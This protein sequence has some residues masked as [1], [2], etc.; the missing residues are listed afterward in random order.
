[1]AYIIVFLSFYNNVTHRYTE[2]FWT[3][4]EFYVLLAAFLFLPKYGWRGLI[5]ATAVPVTIGAVSCYFILPESPRWL[6]S[7]GRFKEAEKI[8]E[9]CALLSP[10]KP[11]PYTFDDPKAREKARERARAKAKKNKDKDK[12]KDKK[13]I[14]IETTNNINTSN[15]A[16]AIDT[17]DT[18]ASARTTSLSEAFE[19]TYDSLKEIMFSPQMRATTLKIGTVWLCF[20][21]GYY[22]VILL[23]THLYSNQSSDNS[24]NQAECSFEYGDIAVNTS[25]EVAGII[26]SLLTI[27]HF[28]RRETQ[29]WNYGAGA[30][31]L[32]IMGV[33][34]LNRTTIAILGYIMRMCAMAA[35]Q[36]T[37]VMTPELY[38]TR[39]RATAHSLVNCMARFGALL[40]PF[41]VVSNLNL[42]FIVVVLG[43]VNVVAAVAVWSLKETNGQAMDYE[44]NEE[45]EDE[46]DGTSNP[47]AN[48]GGLELPDRS[49]NINIS[50][51]VSL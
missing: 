51:S 40:S 20:G 6:V 7:Q 32:L 1:M 45:N 48:S 18:E 10:T 25:S 31:A 22:G 50:K 2:F 9:E 33:I 38:P 14:D 16:I 42:P 39:V 4:G 43:L 41:L 15:G 28:G 23:V 49:I 13:P 44:E 8:I 12:D 17:C 11:T 35:S 47:M 30:V 46:V 36:T 27:D 24:K 37:W 5:F 34:P 26:V 21:F 3:A 29:M 19:Q